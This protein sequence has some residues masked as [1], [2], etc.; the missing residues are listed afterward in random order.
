MVCESYLKNEII[1]G[2]H[3][4]FNAILVILFNQTDMY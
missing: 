2:N 4:S 1:L 3:Q